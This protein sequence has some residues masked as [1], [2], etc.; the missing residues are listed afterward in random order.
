MSVLLTLSQ[1][2][3]VLNRP[4]PQSGQPV[5]E[6]L[7]LTTRLWCLSVQGIRLIV[8]R[9]RI[10]WI[11]SFLSE[12]ILLTLLYVGDVNCILWSWS[13]NRCFTRRGFI[14]CE[15]LPG[16]WHH[17][18]VLCKCPDFL[19]DSSYSSGWLNLLLLGF[20]TMDWSQ[21]WSLS[22]LKGRGLDS[23]HPL[24]QEHA[25]ERT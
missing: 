4:R 7:L 19:C 23:N 11:I 18:R 22:S 8:G 12:G 6:L 2:R 10:R 3:P 24:D 17:R 15:G 1:M 9:V 13:L 21:D 25:G 20:V 14:M 5:L 16:M